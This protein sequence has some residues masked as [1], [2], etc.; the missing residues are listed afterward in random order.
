M[1]RFALPLLGLAAAAAVLGL[2]TWA[3]SQGPA[4]PP[5]PAH[6]VSA[7]TPT[8]LLA[9]TIADGAPNAEQLRR[10]Q[11]LTIAGDCMSCHIRD[12]GQPFGGGLGMNTPFGVIFSANITPDRTTGIGGWTNDQ[13]HRAMH[14][15]IGAHGEN[16]YPAFPYPWFSRASRADND[17]I[18]AYL[19]TIP[20]VSYVPP[21]NRLPFP[22][23]IRFMVKAWNLLFFRPHDF[24][25]DARQSAEWN[26]GAYLVSGLGHCGGCH[27]P[28]NF[29]GATDSGRALRGG[30]LD[31]WV[32]PDLTANARTGLGAWS[33]DDISEFLRTGRNAHA[34]AGGS[35][36]EVVSYSTSLMT[37]QDR[38]AIAVYLKSQTASPDRAAGTPDLGA[39]RRGAAVYSDACASCHLENGVGQ[40]RFFPPLGHDAKLQQADPTGLEHLIL[41]GGR[42]GPTT[43]RP[44]PLTMPSFAWKLTDGEIADVSTY[45]RN[46]WGNQAPQVPASRVRD[47]RHRLGLE[48]VHYTANSGDRE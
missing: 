21:A 39:M 17:A 16:L 47:L 44:S 25:T 12:G 1:G 29:L 35:M 11:A 23:N 45:I 2:A 33:V 38:H 4:L 7:V 18:F 19:K 30:D 24:Q 6:P 26:H 13:F 43:T 5:L 3:A 28:V 32:A 46:S 20:A 15:G 27:T 14:D 10:G 34:G 37:D 22:L 42:V 31:S 8:G 48:A 36:A 41:A 40:P 9:E